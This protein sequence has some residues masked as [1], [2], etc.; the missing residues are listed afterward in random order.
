MSAF[1]EFIARKFSPI[2][3]HEFTIKLDEEMDDDTIVEYIKE[4]LDRAEELTK[5]EN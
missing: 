3:V 4:A 5:E 2:M 1:N